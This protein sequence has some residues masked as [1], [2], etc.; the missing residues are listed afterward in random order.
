MKK[1]IEINATT[2]QV[3]GNETDWDSSYG[4][5]NFVVCPHCFNHIME[6]QNTTAWTVLETLFAISDVRTDCKN[7]NA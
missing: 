6:K 5:E 4:K 7:E 3:C 2:C 1:A